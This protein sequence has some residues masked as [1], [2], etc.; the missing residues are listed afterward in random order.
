MPSKPYWLKIFFAI[1]ILVLTDQIFKNAALAF[2]SQ[3]PVNLSDYFSFE[4]YKNFGIAFGVPVTGGLLY[5]AIF[6]FLLLLFA[7]KFLDMR[8]LEGGEAAGLIFLLAGAAGNIIDRLRWGYIIDFISVKSI[9]VF[10]P[11]DVF[12]V[13]GGIILLRIFLALDKRRGRADKILK[14]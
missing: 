14:H 1:F 8:R 11:A 4:I 7:G 3:G 12:I 9:F 6:I 2:L 13:I 5:F 10:N